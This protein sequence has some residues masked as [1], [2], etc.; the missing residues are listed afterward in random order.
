MYRNGD[1]FHVVFNY[2]DEFGST[3]ARDLCL[4]LYIYLFMCNVLHVFRVF[5]NSDF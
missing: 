1:T 4:N 5:Y 2:A 3:G